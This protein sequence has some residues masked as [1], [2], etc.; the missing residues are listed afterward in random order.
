MEENKETKKEWATPEIF[1][2]DVDRTTSG[3]IHPTEIA[4]TAGPS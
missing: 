4:T 2:L 1:D 3:D